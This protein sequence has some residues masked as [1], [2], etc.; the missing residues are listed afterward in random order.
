MKRNCLT[1]RWLENI[2]GT[3][4]Y[5][6]W[7]EPNVIDHAF[8]QTEQEAE[9]YKCY[10]YTSIN[11]RFCCDCRYYGVDYCRHR[12][13]TAID[14]NLV[15]ITRIDKVKPPCRFFEEKNMED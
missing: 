9:E 3:D 10:E 6:C 1:C 14:D 13:N 4:R 8:V 5:R 12:K 11:K 15:T 7:H 2:S